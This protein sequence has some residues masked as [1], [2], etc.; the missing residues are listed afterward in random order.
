MAVKWGKLVGMK[1]N[2]PSVQYGNI[3]MKLPNV[4]TASQDAAA[5]ANEG[6]LFYDTTTNTMKFSDGAN[7]TALSTSVGT[8]Q[9]VT[10]EGKTSNVTAVEFTGAVS[11][12]TGLLVGDGTR[13]LQLYA[14]ATDSYIAS[15]VGDIYLVPTGSDVR[16][17]GNI[18]ASGTLNITGTSTLG[19]ITA[20]A[21]CTF[22]ASNVEKVDSNFIAA[23]GAANT[24]TGTLVDAG[25]V[26][27]ALADG[28]K[29]LIDLGA[30]T[31]QAGANTF[32]LNAGG[33]VAIVSHYNI[34]SNIGTAYA[35][36]G[37]IELVY[38]TTSSVWMDMSQ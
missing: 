2:D 10:T 26:N 16:V 22:A 18:V 25:S 24:I 8:L 11:A 33:A 30:K 12:V 35:A 34:A 31:L 5:T 14:S 7:W 6:N 20:G 21:S 3:S 13:K 9:Q 36:N 1:D 28:L 38:N 27:V 32:N 23:G 37:F 4:T 17:T 19:V 15:A 29:V